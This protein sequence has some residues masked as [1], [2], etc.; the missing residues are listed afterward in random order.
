M[1]TRASAVYGKAGPIEGA[2]FIG[3]DTGVRNMP[4]YIGR[5]GATLTTTAT[6]AYYI[7]YFVA[8]AVT[9]S[10]LLTFNQGVGDNTDTYRLA[11][12]A[13]DGTAGPGTLIQ[14]VGEVTL[15]GASALRTLSATINLEAYANQWVWVMFHANQAA[16]MYDMKCSISTADY[17]TR[18]LMFGTLGS[19]FA[20]TTADRI[21]RYVD[22]AYGAAAA[23][24][25]TPT[26]T[27]AAA[28]AFA[29][30]K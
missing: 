15:T 12:Y 11:I 10:S 24:A 26:A 18:A 30:V 28:P 13:N 9:F 6:R 2:P 7:P 21:F 5:S 1:G 23:T 29:L 4:H 17:T 3:Y 8:E 20:S 22:T 27:T 16:D 14:D 25:V 19:E